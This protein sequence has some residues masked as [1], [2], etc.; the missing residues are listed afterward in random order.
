M[1]RAVTVGR[2]C[3]KPHAFHSLEDDGIPSLKEIL[4][5]P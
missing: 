1:A 5:R 2:R 3:V 4:F